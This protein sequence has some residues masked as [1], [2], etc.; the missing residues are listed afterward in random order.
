MWSKRP[1]D[2]VCRLHTLLFY[3][4]GKTSRPRQL[5]ERAYTPR[6]LRVHH[7][8]GG[9]GCQQAGMAAG[10]ARW[11]LTYWDMKQRLWNTKAPTSVPT[12][13]V[14]LTGDQMFK[15]LRG[16]F[17]YQHTSAWQ[18]TILLKDYIK[19]CFVLFIFLNTNWEDLQPIITRVWHLPFSRQESVSL[20]AF[21]L[22]SLWPCRFLAS[23][24]HM[25]SLLTI[26]RNFHLISCTTMWVYQ[27]HRCVNICL[28]V[29]V[30][31]TCA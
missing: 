31:V 9:S 26:E 27:V 17:W 8:H 15:C 5:N 7:L 20:T 24:V 30:G 19:R 2:C 25:L 14:P 29:C 1:S 23:Q 10:A 22:R 21:C 12:L 6:G 16:L 11:G 13:R 4:S 3:C 18:H 28:Y